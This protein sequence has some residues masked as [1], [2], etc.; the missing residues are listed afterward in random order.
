[1]LGLA[2]AMDSDTSAG[3]C[4]QLLRTFPATAVVSAYSLLVLVTSRRPGIFLAPLPSEPAA[5]ANA[6]PPAKPFPENN[7]HTIK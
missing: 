7:L 6:V 5:E 3:N 4:L 1:M 2:K